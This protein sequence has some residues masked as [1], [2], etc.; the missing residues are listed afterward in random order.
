MTEKLW[1]L[2]QEMMA[3]DSLLAEN[4]DPETL[5]IL[6]GAK[7]KLG[8]DIESKMKNI[9]AYIGECKA[10]VEY[11]KGEEQR[12]ATKRK[13]IERRVDWLRDMVLGQM[14]LTGRQKAE[15]GTWNVTLYR[16]PDKVVLVDGADEWLPDDL[17][18]ITRTP[19]KT[20]IKAAMGESKEFKVT[21]DGR[22]IV[23]ANVEPGSETVRI[24]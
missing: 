2:N 8:Q 14:K 10:R 18:R 23:V 6:S 15:Y 13:T 16:T 19:N 17:C 21:V 4:T 11:L 9:L 22:D 3:I 24:A 5:E 1:E 12:I 7:E 20:A